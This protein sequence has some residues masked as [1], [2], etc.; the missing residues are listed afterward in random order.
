L[1]QTPEKQGIYLS[2]I[3][4]YFASK[5][6]NLPVAV[7]IVEVDAGIP[8]QRIV[9]FSRVD[10]SAADVNISVN[11]SVAT[12]FEFSDPVYLQD[13]TEYAFVVTTNSTNYEIYKAT[14]GQPDLLDGK[15]IAKQ[16]YAGV[17]FMSQNMS[18]W[19]EDQNSD[20]KFVLNKC[21]FDTNVVGNYDVSSTILAINYTGATTR[22][23][24][25]DTVTSSS[26]GTGVVVSDDGSQLLL[27]G[28][29]GTF[30]DQDTL[31][32]DGT[33]G[34]F[35]TQSGAPIA[36]PVQSEYATLA[37]FNFS[38]VELEGTTISYGYKFPGDASYTSFDGS[39]D[40]ELDSRKIFDTSS[41]PVEAQISLQT[42]NANISPIINI[43]RS[44]VIVVDND[45]N[46][47]ISHT[48]DQSVSYSGLTGTFQIGETLNSSSGGSAL[49]EADNGSVLT[50]SNVTGT[51]ANL[52]T[53]TGATSGATATQNGLIVALEFIPGEVV[54]GATSGATGVVV[55]D[56]DGIVYLKNHNRVNF[57]NL[58]RISGNISGTTA[59][60]TSTAQLSNFGTYLTLPVTLANPADDLRVIFDAKVPSGA[61]IDVS[62]NAEGYISKYATI[63]S[64]G[65]GDPA[66]SL[67]SSPLNGLEQ[68]IVGQTTNIYDITNLAAPVLQG[69]AVVTKVHPS[70][71]YL[72]SISD[73]TVFT[74]TTGSNTFLYTT[75]IIPGAI[76]TGW[77]SGTTYTAGDYLIHNDLL[78]KS[79]VTGTTG[80]PSKNSSD[81]SLVP[82]V[83]SEPNLLETTGSQWRKMK[84][85]KVPTDSV[86]GIME[87]T[88]I[89]DEFII[90]EF[91]TFSVKVEMKGIDVV[92]VPFIRNFRAIAA[93]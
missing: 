49:I 90:D 66:W 68:N 88:Y 44:S 18:T 4:L 80:E 32:G 35:A 84:L 71:V 6:A 34:N 85:E 92:D 27:S 47:Y 46:K 21:V 22:F 28:V 73:P 24:R 74:G 59:T 29:S 82:S 14:M 89:P 69:K 16:P 52:D 26:G 17:M 57:N 65:A 63:F 9:P 5:D 79:N 83:I 37:K 87:Y 33:N 56:R 42:T 2:S 41:N 60:T 62:F 43:G 38:A 12:A 40:I 75:D 93:I 13:G 64:A 7:H 53:L 70:S 48:P 54:T 72:Q 1:V 31:T 39:I 25:G 91:I 81:W 67:T 61:S 51:F 86:N 23:E 58:E 30:A 8:T 10:K 45:D 15:G 55:Y 20:V 19:T 50:L 78:W 76:L 77:A 11:S 36:N 3:D